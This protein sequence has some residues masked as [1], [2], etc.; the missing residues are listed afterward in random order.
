MLSGRS[1]LQNSVTLRRER[2]ISVVVYF[3]NIFLRVCSR[4]TNCCLQLFRI[5]AF[6][7]MQLGSNKENSEA[8]LSRL[9]VYTVLQVGTILY[10]CSY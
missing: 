8:L 1:I 3:D 6:V 2:I 5:Y 7:F 10:Y 4:S 9:Y